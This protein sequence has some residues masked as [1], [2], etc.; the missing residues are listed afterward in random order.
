MTAMAEVTQYCEAWSDAYARGDIDAI[1]NSYTDGTV[2]LTPGMPTIRGGSELASLFR[3]RSDRVS[4]EPGDVFLESGE[5]I[6]DVG[7]YVVA[8]QDGEEQRRGRYVAVYQRQPDGTVKIVVDGSRSWWT[9]RYRID[10]ARGSS[11]I[12]L[13]TGRKRFR[14]AGKSE[15]WLTHRRGGMK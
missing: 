11:Q 3:D 12:R 14:A 6:V 2:Y 1:A 7:Q 10:R 13:A 8:D 4:F 9:C 5:L 15:L